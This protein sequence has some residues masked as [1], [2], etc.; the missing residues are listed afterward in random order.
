MTDWEGGTRGAAFVSGGVVPVERRNSTYEGLV[1]QV[2]WYYTLA[3]L[4]GVPPAAVL[5]DSGPVAPDS[6]DV[7]PALISDAPSPRTELVYN[8]NGNWSGALRVGD[9]KVLKGHPNEAFRGTDDW[10]P[11]TP[12]RPP[13]PP[14]A[15]VLAA[16]HRCEG[17]SCPCVARPCLYNLVRVAYVYLKH[18][19]F[20]DIDSHDPSH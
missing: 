1:S 10:S 11:Q 14:R 15:G 2:D 6:I 20:D 5:A 12:W 8:I 19:V 16:P 3:S 9:Y 4:A 13:S 7:W 17:S 18:R